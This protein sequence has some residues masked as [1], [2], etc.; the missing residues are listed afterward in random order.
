MASEVPAS[1]LSTLVTCRL[2]SASRV[3]TREKRTQN[4][5]YKIQNIKYKI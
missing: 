1:E 5:K 2:L 4:T 3:F